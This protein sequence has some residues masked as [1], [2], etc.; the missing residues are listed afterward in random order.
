MKKIVY[1]L[2][3]GNILVILIFWWI[4]SH[5]LFTSRIDDV[6]L[7]F[8]RLTGLLAVFSILTQFMLIGR[9]IW[10]EKVFGLDKL[11]R[12]HRLNAYCSLTFMVLH[13][14]F[15][16]LSY[17]V[18][19]HSNLVAQF[20][21]FITSF[22]DVLNAFIA[23]LIF[24]GII[25]TSIY[26]VRRKLKYE[27]WYFV[28][29]FT[30]LA[31]LLAWG[32]QLK[33]GGDFIES[34]AFTY[35][36]YILYIF[37]FGNHLIFRFVKQWYNFF[38]YRFK[39]QKVVAETEE[40][41]SIYIDGKNIQTFTI[42]PGQFMIFRF[43][44][45]HFWWQAHPFSLSNIPQNTLR[46]T[47]KNVGDFTSAIKDIQPGTPVVI[48]GPYGI[49]T[50]RSSQKNKILLIAGGI[51]IT[52]IRSLIEYMAHNKDVVLLYSNKTE[53]EIVFKK[54]IDELSKKYKFPAYYILSQEQGKEGMISGRIDGE[55]IKKLVPDIMEREVYICGPQLMTDAIKRDLTTMGVSPNLIHFEKFSL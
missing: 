31:V 54:E 37:V 33:N 24:L 27:L 46:I 13:I 39:V 52:P 14:V 50:E 6:L 3:F 22:E 7:A 35:Y 44:N 2:L 47:V 26:I 45:T 9:A 15:L 42:E 48:D 41:T 30:Y 20:V 17:A 36:W 34:K 32:H 10:I 40:A 49:F 19:T 53:K 23:F 55:K 11:T 29:L 43:L 1:S 28:H 18:T 12:V 21:S 5:T 51:G 4:Y 25:F 16:T 8:G 38:K